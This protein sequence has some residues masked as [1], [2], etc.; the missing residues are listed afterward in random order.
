MKLEVGEFYLSAEG[1]VLQIVG[2][3]GDNFL[4]SSYNSY[5]ESG[6]QCSTLPDYD[7]I[8]H[9]PKELHYKIIKVINEYHTGKDK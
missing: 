3:D 1:E 2:K 5:F 7:L 8:A 6:Q 4:D 9:I